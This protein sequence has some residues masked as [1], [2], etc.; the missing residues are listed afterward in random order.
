MT[1]QEVVARAALQRISAPVCTDLVVSITAAKDVYG[2]CVRPQTVRSGTPIKRVTAGPARE[3]VVAV[4]AQKNVVAIAAIKP[5]VANSSVKAVG[6]AVA[7]E[8]VVTVSAY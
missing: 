8:V 2:I 6:A 1:E 5:V 4:P 3:V 7:C